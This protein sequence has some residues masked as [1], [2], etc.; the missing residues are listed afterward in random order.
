MALVDQVATETF[1]FTDTPQLNGD[2]AVSETFT[3]TESS[4]FFAVGSFPWMYPFVAEIRD[5]RTTA[6][7]LDYQGPNGSLLQ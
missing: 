2:K 1:T 6:T 3:F 7:I 4:S 5:S